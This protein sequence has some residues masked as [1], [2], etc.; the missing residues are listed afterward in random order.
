MKSTVESLEPTRVKVTV[1]ADYDE[2]KPDMDKAYREIAQQVSIP[3][4]RKG[5]V[6]PRIIDQRFGRG[7]VIEQVVNEVLPGLYSRAVM[8]NELRPVS[9]P[10]VDV[11][12]VPAAEGEPGGLLKFTAEVDVVPAFDV[13]EFEGLEVEVSPVEVDDEAVQAELDE[14]RGRF[15]TLKNLER[16]AEDGDYLTLDLEAKVGDEVIDTLSEVSYE[17]G[18]GNM[19][20]GQD[21]ALR[22]QEAGAE[23]TFTS[24][25]RGGEYA[26]QDATIEVKV[27]SVKERELPEADDDFAQMVS[28]FD[29][30][31]EL[32]AD[33]REQ[34]ARRGVSQ[35]ALEARDKLLA[36][37]LEQTEILLPE[38]AIEHELS[39]RV[40]ENTSDEDK[41]SIREAVENDLRQSI[42]LETLAEKSDVQVG[43]QELFEFMM[44]T[45]QT[46]GMDPGQ[47]FQDQRQIQNMM[48][49]LARTKALVAVLRGATVKDTNGELVDISEFTAD[50]AEA[51]APSFEEQIEEV[52]EEVAEEAKED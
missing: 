7:V 43:Q 24:T 39:H 21:E 44:Q 25:V 22:G 46:F 18:S 34:V 6:P 13:P 17:L 8:D 20:E 40:D 48:V 32:L 36:Q 9:Q 41:Q 10:D 28:E 3:G 30:A 2:L 15:A 33:L 31:E 52:T 45:A 49:E 27:I 1:E 19:L 42:F 11:V 16:A 12:E 50:P 51:E 47:L 35:Q 4:F 5:H 26:G 23:V 14:L 29:T 37:L 38:S